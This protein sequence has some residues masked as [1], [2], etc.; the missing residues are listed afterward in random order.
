MKALMFVIAVLLTGCTI[1]WKDGPM[2]SFKQDD[3]ACKRD[4]EGLRRPFLGAAALAEDGR[5]RRMY[6]ECMEAR[7]Y[8]R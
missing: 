7:G 4:A 2:A 6:I 3:Y 5:V 1:Q 8:S